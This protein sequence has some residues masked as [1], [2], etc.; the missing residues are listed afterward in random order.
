MNKTLIALVALTLSAV[1]FVAS[2][3]SQ[4]GYILRA[5][6][7]NPAPLE[8]CATLGTVSACKSSMSYYINIA[9]SNAPLD[10]ACAIILAEGISSKAVAYLTSD[11]DLLS[12]G[13]FFIEKVVE[14]NCPNDIQE[15]AKNL[16]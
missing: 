2:A 15:L 13:N 6:D 1:P 5:N 11:D 3:E 14:G 4:S 8:K 7:V 12:A 10:K 16:L 9:D